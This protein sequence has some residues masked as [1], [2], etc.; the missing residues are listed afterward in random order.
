[1][2]MWPDDNT[3]GQEYGQMGSGRAGIQVE[4]ETVEKSLRRDCIRVIQK[5]DTWTYGRLSKD[6]FEAKY[7]TLVG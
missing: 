6:D 3:A 1:M 2:G 5:T 4:M 7:D